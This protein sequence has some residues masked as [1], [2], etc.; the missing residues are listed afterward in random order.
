MLIMKLM[1]RFLTNKSANA[2]F[3]IARKK[4]M[5]TMYEDGIL[6]AIQGHTT[7]DEVHRVING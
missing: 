4:G 2:I 3:A 1:M 5:L 7:L 6:K